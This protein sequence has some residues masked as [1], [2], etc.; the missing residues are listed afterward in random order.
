MIARRKRAR[1]AAASSAAARAAQRLGDQRQHV[2]EVVVAGAALARAQALLDERAEA[3]R[4]RR[5]QRHR[6]VGEL[7]ERGQQLRDAGLVAH[8]A[9]AIGL[10]RSS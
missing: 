4:H 9:Q 3:L 1:S 2:V 10:E 5:R 6:G 7:L 8:A